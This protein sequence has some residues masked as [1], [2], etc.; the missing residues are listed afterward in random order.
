MP[1]NYHSKYL[2]I[3]AVISVFFLSACGKQTIQPG[4][5]QV[6]APAEA[7]DSTVVEG[8]GAVSADLSGG[9]RPYIKNGKTYVPLTSASGFVEEGI[10]SWYGKDFH[11]KQ[12]ANGERYDMNAMTAAHKTL[13]FGSMVRVTNLENN[14]SVVVRINDRGPFVGERI[15]DLT[16]SGA[17]QLDFAESGTAIVRL[18]ALEDAPSLGQTQKGA[19]SLPPAAGAAQAPSSSASQSVSQ[20]ESGFYIQVGAFSVEANANRLVQQLRS[21]GYNVRTLYADSNKLWRVQVGPYARLE[22]ANGV[23]RTLEEEYGR[24]FVISY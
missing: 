23:A 18:T 2:L 16:Y 7:W 13:P 6:Q 5:D 12:T 14:R 3:L 11:G 21:R 1:V 10:A 4:P 9:S 19:V 8:D 20:S 22:Q 15:I 17:K 24:N